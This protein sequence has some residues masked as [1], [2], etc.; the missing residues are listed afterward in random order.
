V[1]QSWMRDMA[2]TKAGR[3]SP[4]L[5]EDALGEVQ[6]ILHRLKNQK[7]LPKSRSESDEKLRKDLLRL[8][9]EIQGL[10]AVAS[11]RAKIR[12]RCGEK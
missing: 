5:T 1:D 6:S 11:G 10:M 8:D 2:K 4:L 7:A 9:I 3:V 12:R